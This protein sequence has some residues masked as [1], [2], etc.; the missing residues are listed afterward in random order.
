MRRVRIDH[1]GFPHIIETI[2]VNASPELLVAFRNTN[3]HFRNHVSKL[4]DH[5]EISCF[6]SADRESQPQ[7]DDFIEWP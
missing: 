7:Q 3:R 1:V 4:T 5:N 6:D 2:L